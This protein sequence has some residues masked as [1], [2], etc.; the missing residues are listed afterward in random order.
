MHNG[1]DGLND[2]YRCSQSQGLQGLDWLMFCL[3]AIS[4]IFVGFLGFSN[5]GSGGSLV[6]RRRTPSEPR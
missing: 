3:T 5:R 2:F 1:C 6:V 4:I